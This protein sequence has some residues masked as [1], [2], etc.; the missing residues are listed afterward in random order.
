MLL[1]HE[2]LQWNRNRDVDFYVHPSDIT[3]RGFRLNY[4]LGGPALQTKM[5]VRWLAVLD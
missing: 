5:R 4:H 1:V 2:E 3:T